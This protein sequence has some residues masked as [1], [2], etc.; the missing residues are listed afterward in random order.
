MIVSDALTALYNHSYYALNEKG[1]AFVADYL[2]L[3]LQN[4]VANLNLLYP[5]R[6]VINRQFEDG[7]N[8]SID[9]NPLGEDEN[10]VGIERLEVDGVE[11]KE[12][13][14]SE[15]EEYT[16]ILVWAQWAGIIY[17]NEEL[18]DYS[19]TDVDI[20]AVQWRTIPELTTAT[21]DLTD[22]EI[23]L[24]YEYGNYKVLE[25][26]LICYVGILL[27][28]LQPYYFNV[29][30][31]GSDRVTVSEIIK[32]ASLEQKYFEDSKKRIKEFYITTDI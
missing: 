24:L 25:L 27:Y 7:T 10:T 31:I 3:D 23:G 19:Y 18:T 12:V 1:E 4:F 2:E 29:G 14:I 21:L 11:V 17:F 6:K 13:D 8:S 20:Y 9:F 22:I 15:L 32:L 16:D 5:Q 28:E 30:T 26:Q